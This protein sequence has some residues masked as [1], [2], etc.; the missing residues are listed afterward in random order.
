MSDP[1]SSRIVARALS[2]V[3]VREMRGQNDGIP[4]ERYMGGR[5]EPW[6][7][8][9]IAW[10]FRSE[11]RPLPKDVPPRPEVANPLAGVQYMEYVFRELGWLV[12]APK[13]GDVVFFKDR[14]TSDRGHGRHVGL[15]T[16]VSP[17]GR[18]QTV[19]G[20]LGDRVAVMVYSPSNPRI[21]SF[22]RVPEE[23]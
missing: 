9:F 23:V 16:S 5:R 4:S 11:G 17:D 8:H 10:L 7:A 12:Q 3:G 15:V 2:E 22:G 14:G 20:N 13:P 21:A 1:L 18:F 19:E 6:C